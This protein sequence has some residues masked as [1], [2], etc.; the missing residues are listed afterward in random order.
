MKLSSTHAIVVS[1]ILVAF[2]SARSQ[3][4]T[5]VGWDSVAALLQTTTT[6]SG[7]YQ[8]YNLPRRDITLRVGGIAIS[9]SLALG[10]W[11]GFS[12]TPTN[13]TMMGDLVLLDSELKPALAE[14]S[15]QNIDVT[16]IHNHLSGE[17]PQIRNVHFHGQGAATELSRR[18][19]RVIALTATPRPVANPAPR[20]VTFDTAVAFR[21]LGI[22]GR[23]QGDIVQATYM[24]VPGSVNIHDHAVE[25][26]LALRS[27]VV[28]QFFDST[29]AF[30][31]GDFAVV[32]ARVDPLLDALAAN[33]ITATAV[34]SH[35]V[36]EQPTIYY[37]HFWGDGRPAD[38]LKG[39]RAA[40]D[41]G[42]VP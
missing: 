30:A 32:A 39:L 31:T 25:P 3:S 29:R 4:G 17:E 2:D 12:G 5:A 19:N 37:I 36:G 20:P 38:V 16:A 21:S 27:P 13:A 18:L 42:R 41:A 26:S 28:V 6:P 23:A 10:A 7:G 8:R 1:L 14:L 35:L 40:A 11:V 34:H 24:L 9:P 15:R 33:G 22:A